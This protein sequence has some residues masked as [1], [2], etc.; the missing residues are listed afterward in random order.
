MSNDTTTAKN[1]GWSD[2]KA[3]PTSIGLGEA[4]IYAITV[5]LASVPIF[6]ADPRISTPFA[7]VVLLVGYQIG[8]MVRERR[9]D[10]AIHEFILK[11]NEAIRELGTDNSRAIQELG[12]QI[13]ELSHLVVLNNIDAAYA[14]LMDALKTS[15]AVLNTRI[16]VSASSSSMVPATHPYREAIRKYVELGG[17]L[18]EIV[19][20]QETLVKDAQALEAVARDKTNYDFRIL[21]APSS[22]FL[23]FTILE[24][25]DGRR[26]SQEVVI[27]W[28]VAAGVSFNQQCF[29]LRG[30]QIREVF[31]DIFQALWNASISPRSV[32]ATS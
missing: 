3:Y 11:T 20:R 2:A 10:K 7:V 25:D 29:I 6:F 15:S 13:P 31:S 32:V 23:N 30:P 4:I 24:Y 22:V 27:G 16:P 18:R 9:T 17:S 1:V 8:Q 19:S 21:D 14:Y 26:D 5:A 28:A 12:R